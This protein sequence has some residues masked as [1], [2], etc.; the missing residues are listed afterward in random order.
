[1]RYLTSGEVCEAVGIPMPTLNKWVS[2][3]AV[4]PAIPSNGT[5]QQ[6][7]FSLAQVLAISL[8]RWLRQK[9]GWSLRAAGNVMRAL[10]CFGEDRLRADFTEGRTHLW[11][12]NDNCM[13]LLFDPATIHDANPHVASLLQQAEAAGI[14]VEADVLDVATA[15]ADLNSKLN[16][17]ASKAK[18][19]A[20]ART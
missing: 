16:K 9:K 19:K 2:E 8:G 13:P 10:L 1:M 6:R 15:W 11:I 14:A 20:K 5:G 7:R 17:R 18:Q 12:V 4:V 3:G